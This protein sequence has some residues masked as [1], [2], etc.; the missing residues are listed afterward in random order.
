MTR[1]TSLF[2]IERRRTVRRRFSFE[3][4]ALVRV[5]FVL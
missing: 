2:G 5:N 4:V 1:G 3:E